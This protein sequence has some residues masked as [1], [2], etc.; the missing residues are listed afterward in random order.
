MPIHSVRFNRRGEQGIPVPHP[1]GLQAT[2]PCLPVYVEIPIA[3]ARRLERTGEP[4]PLPGSGY[5]L[6]DTGASDSAVDIRVLDQLG[7]QPIDVTL[8]TTA[9]GQVRQPKYPGCLSFPGTT[10]PR[11]EFAGL[12]GADLSGYRAEEGRSIV[13]L[14]GRDVLRHFVMIYNGYDAYFTLAF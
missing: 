1:N 9:G 11:R 2:G 12:L 13:A 3:L 7:V 5:A 14:L 10:L 4:I 8:V 6:V